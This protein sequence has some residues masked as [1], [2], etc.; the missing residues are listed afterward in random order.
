MKVLFIRGHADNPRLMQIED[1]NPS[2]AGRDAEVEVAAGVAEAYAANRERRT[3]GHERAVAVARGDFYATAGGWACFDALDVGMVE[4]R[5]VAGHVHAVALADVLKGHAD[6]VAGAAAECIYVHAYIQMR[7]GGVFFFVHVAN[8][9]YYCEKI[10][11]FG[12]KH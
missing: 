4:G 9:V 11:K 2:G 10:S 3:A 5:E 6:A 8:I 12:E 7:G 1:H